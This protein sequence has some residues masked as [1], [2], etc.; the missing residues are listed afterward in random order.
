MTTAG[1]SG[2]PLAKKLGIKED[3]KCHF[4]HIPEYYFNLFEE[5]PA[6]ETV[7]KPEAGS[8]DFAHA[9]MMSQ[10]ELKSMI[11]QVKDH[12]KK[13][14]TLWLSWPKKASKLQTDL[15]G[16]VIRNFGLDIGLVDV[17]VAAID[18][19]WSGLKFMYRV[20]DR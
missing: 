3:F 20:K 18:D 4:V 13:D 5:L 8:I 11:P 14:G 2:T 16:N 15:D 1:Y 10:A 12:L 9:F 17:K 6:I 19:I 7:E